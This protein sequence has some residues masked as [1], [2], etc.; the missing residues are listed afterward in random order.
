MHSVRGFLAPPGAR[1]E[2][3]E[4]LIQFPELTSLE[5]AR[6]EATDATLAKAAARSSLEC[7]N[8]SDTQIGDAGLLLF[9]NARNLGS[10]KLARSQVTANGLRKFLADKNGHTLDLRGLGLTD[11]DLAQLPLDKFNVLTLDDNPLTN[12]CL[13]HLAHATHVHLNRTR[14]DGSGLTALKNIVYLEIDHIALDDEQLLEFMK[15]RPNLEGLSI[16]GTQ[17][18][19]ACLPALE[20]VVYLQLGETAITP[21]GLLE[22]KINPPS[23]FSLND[24]KF[25]GSLFVLNRWSIGHLDLRSSA[26]LIKILE[27]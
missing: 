17:V 5:L 26:S 16:R 25:D 2:D 4:Y 22:S 18:T 24:R 15:Q 13:P 1:I 11:A 21:T 3:I 14:V 20:K 6:T 19:D 8:F 12:A 27:R 9:K 10:I 7:L 23:Q